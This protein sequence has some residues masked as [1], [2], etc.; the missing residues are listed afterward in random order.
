MFHKLIYWDHNRLRGFT[1]DG[2][3]KEK[4]SGEQQPCGGKRLAGTSPTYKVVLGKVSLI[5]WPV[6][7]LC[8]R[9]NVGG[10]PVSRYFNSGDHELN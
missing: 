4:I 9:L 7:I 1:E 3:Q 6:R 2:G 8:R 10:G 5:K